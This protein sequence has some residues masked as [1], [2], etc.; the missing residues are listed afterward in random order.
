[1]NILKSKTKC[2]DIRRR[3]I[4]LACRNNK[5]R[6]LCKIP[7]S[8]TALDCNKQASQFEF[9][10]ELAYCPTF[11]RYQNHPSKLISFVA[12]KD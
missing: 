9:A 2:P 3:R 6:S 7:G 10:L 12:A 5:M 8:C 1:M 11:E 4:I